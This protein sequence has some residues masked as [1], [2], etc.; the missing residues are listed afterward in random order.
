MVETYCRRIFAGRVSVFLGAFA[1]WRKTN[2][3]FVMSAH[4]TIRMKKL[5]FH[6]GFS[7][8]LLLEYFSKICGENPSFFK[9]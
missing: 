8:N 7:L 2:I 3:S 6:D 4:P 5:G 1:K 9:I